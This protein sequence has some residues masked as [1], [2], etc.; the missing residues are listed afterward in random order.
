VI[1]AC[2]QWIVSG[3]LI[4]GLHGSVELLGRLLRLTQ[5]GQ[6]QTQAFLT[7]LGV[8]LVLYW[9]LR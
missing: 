3:L 5:T 4:R 1:A 2:D 9:A 6:V 8:L 7:L